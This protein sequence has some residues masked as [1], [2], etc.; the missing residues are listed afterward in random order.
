VL[1]KQERVSDLLRRAGSMKDQAYPRAARLTRLFPPV[2]S[3]GGGK[4]AETP[5]FRVVFDIEEALQ[6][7]GG[8]QDL[9]LMAGD[10]LEIPRFENV[11]QVS[12]AVVNPIRLAYTPGKTVGYYVKQ[13]G[14]YLEQADEDNVTLVYP[15][16]RELPRSRS[17]LWFNRQKVE[18]MSTI[19]VPVR[20]TS[21]QSRKSVSPPVEAK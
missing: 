3:E 9:L 12:G 13:A 16:G 7:H 21:V 6:A 2:A 19:N 5:R 20:V 17:I 11:V 14:G 15:D 10:R 18:P 1:E 8:E 4:P